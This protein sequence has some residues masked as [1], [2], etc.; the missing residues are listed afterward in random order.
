[1][2]NEKSRVVRYIGDPVEG[3][4]Q[5]YQDGDW[6]SLSPG[7]IGDFLLGQ[8]PDVPPI[9]A[10][11]PIP[12]S[13][14]SSSIPFL[15][16]SSSSSS[17]PFFSSSSSSSSDFSEFFGAPSS[18]A[19]PVASLGLTRSTGNRG[20][21]GSPYTSLLL[22]SVSLSS[23]NIIYC[24]SLKYNDL[25]D[26]F[27]T[28]SQEIYRLTSSGDF[29]PKCVNMVGSNVIMMSYIEHNLSWPTLLTTITRY[30]YDYAT[31]NMSKLDDEY[32]STSIGY[33]DIECCQIGSNRVLQ[34]RKESGNLV[35]EY[36]IKDF[37][38]STIKNWTTMPYSDI[39]IIRR[40]GPIAV[41]Y[42]NSS[43]NVYHITLNGTFDD[44]VFLTPVSGPVSAIDSMDSV[45]TSEPYRLFAAKGNTTFYMDVTSSGITIGSSVNNGFDIDNTYITPLD[46]NRVVMNGKYNSTYN[47]SAMGRIQGGSWEIGPL[48]ILNGY[49]L[50]SQSNHQTGPIIS[51][52][53]EVSMNFVSAVTDNGF[54][55][56]TQTLYNLPIYCR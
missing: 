50:G 18:Q 28:N 24:S 54:Y 30:S 51:A 15:L 37:S 21:S 36:R 44:I 2:A 53:N 29:Y 39:G 10:P 25:T 34:I 35:Y 13:S 41:M 6:V 11:F 20:T 38:N 7:D 46:D 17:I 49:M 52:N 40:V 5:Y 26:S 43:T 48:T 22:Y 27:S 9:W 56:L 12:I 23:T 47:A 16:S 19:T 8:G 4:L 32:L 3:S 33:S 55:G 31:N 42:S 14:S 45:S 1:M